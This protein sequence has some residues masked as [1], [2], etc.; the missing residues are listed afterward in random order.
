MVNSNQ[1]SSGSLAAGF[2]AIF[3]SI[4]EC[5]YN[6]NQNH[7][8]NTNDNQWNQILFRFYSGALCSRWKWW[9]LLWSKIVG[10]GGEIIGLLGEI[11]GLRGNWWWRVCCSTFGTEFCS[12][13]HL[14]SAVFTK[15][16]ILLSTKNGGNYR[17]FHFTGNWIESQEK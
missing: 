7:N 2:H 17:Y 16:S 9:I 6:D 15:H 13:F 3:A 10:L 5:D 4:A 11:A 8:S 14:K 1:I 12:V